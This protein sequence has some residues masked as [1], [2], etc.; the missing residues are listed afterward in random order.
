[1]S[2]PALGR[3]ERI[4]DL[5][6][7]W[8]TEST[9]FTPWLA[10]PDNLKLLGDTVGIDLEFEA[11]E[12]D[13]GP[14]RADILCKNTLDSSWVLIE[15][16]LER[17]DHTHLGQLLTYAAGLEIVTIIWIAKRFAEEHRA[18]LDW[19]NEITSERFN[20]FGLELELWKIA[21]SPIAP[22][23]NMVAKPNDWTRIVQSSAHR[24]E[25]RSEVKQIQLEFWT[26]FKKYMEEN[27]SIRCQKPSPQHWMNHSIG[28]SGLW[29]TSIAST[30][31][32]ETHKAGPEIRVEFTMGDDNA[33]MYFAFLG[34]QK[35]D[36][37]REIGRQLVW[38]NPLET[39]QS[40]IY[41]RQ[42]SNFQNR[43]EWVQQHEWLRNN[44]ETFHRVFGSRIPQLEALVADES[45][46]QPL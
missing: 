45:D 12:K 43:S 22:K 39:K 4:D 25:G 20:F 38:H 15:N 33:K 1:M 26:A 34:G 24:A 3:L 23:F 31:N 29:L 44:L 30:W 37:E 46:V 35:A 42:A 14:F 41:V 8:I 40:R 6:T 21:D 13:V 9:G 5:R 18:T 32:S 27:S 36:I 17:T 2:T 10:R 7:I 28:R 16:Q 11:Q 19:L